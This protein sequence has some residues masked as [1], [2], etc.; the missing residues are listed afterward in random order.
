[1]MT[2]NYGKF[3]QESKQYFRIRFHGKYCSII[4]FITRQMRQEFWYTFK[5]SHDQNGSLVHYD[6]HSTLN[7]EIE[8]LKVKYTQLLKEY[9]KH[10]DKKYH[11]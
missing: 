4:P 8:Q 10:I 5:P 9:D 6:L 3:V 7:N 1:G 11:L 2:F